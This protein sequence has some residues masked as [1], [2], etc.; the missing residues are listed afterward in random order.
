MKLLELGAKTEEI[1]TIC[2][3]YVGEREM[4]RCDNMQ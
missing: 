4:A 1:R 3:I 2:E